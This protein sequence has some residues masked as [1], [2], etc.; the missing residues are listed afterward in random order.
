MRRHSRAVN[1]V[2]LLC[3]VIMAAASGCG[4]MNESKK[5]IRVGFAYTA[6]HLNVNKIISGFKDQL[7]KEYQEAEIVFVEKHAS[8]DWTQIPATLDALL[9]QKVD[10]VVSIT[11]PVSEQAFKRVPRTVHLCFL[12]VTD[13]VGAGLVDSLAQ[14]SRCTGVSDFAP[15][16]AN[17]KFIRQILPDAKTIGFP[18]NPENQPAVFGLNEIKRLAPKY[19]FTVVEKPLASKDEIS[20]LALELTKTTDC[21]L[22][23]SDNVM[24]EAAPTLVKAATS[25]GKLVFAGDS[26]SIEAGAIG[27]Y[28]IEYPRVGKEGGRI[29]GQILK[30]KKV[31][32][33]PVVRFR[34]GV[35]ELNL[36]TAKTLG[37]DIPLDLKKAAAVVYP[38][39]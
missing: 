21:L 30:G 25:A 4:K 38:A 17:L 15:F 18:Y 39:E 8:G 23:G 7:R 5:P 13:P 32:E 26:T 37:I 19:G 24:F 2:F 31:S 1:A 28:T 33:I 12:G 11:T 20:V 9:A 27:G 3:V 34:D 14:P 36:A 6:P 35:L 22:I 16:E 29:A 10:L